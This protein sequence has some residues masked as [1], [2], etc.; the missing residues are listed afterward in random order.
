LVRVVAYEAQLLAGSPVIPKHRYFFA[1]VSAAI[2]GAGQV[3]ADDDGV[4][5]SELAPRVEGASSCSS[6]L[7][8]DSELSSP[9]QRYQRGELPQLL[10]RTVLLRLTSKP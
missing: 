10:H 9:E 4:F 6:D 3:D 7:D 5:L 2:G 1:R 8:D